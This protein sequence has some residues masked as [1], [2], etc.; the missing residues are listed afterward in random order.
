MRTT[1]LVAFILALLISL[2]SVAAA[3][4][5]VCN[6]MMQTPMNEQSTAGMPCHQQMTGM[7]KAMHNKHGCIDKTTCKSIC[8]SFSAMTAI[9]SDIRHSTFSTVSSSIRMLHQSYTSVTLPN[10]QR[11]PIFL[12]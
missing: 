9:P 3:N 7:Y 6:S 8:A 2:Q 11:P 4:M 10:P 5:S 1:Q 12:S